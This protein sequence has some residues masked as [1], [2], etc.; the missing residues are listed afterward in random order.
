MNFPCD[1]CKHQNKETC[2]NHKRCKPWKT[3][4]KEEWKEVTTRV[5]E[6]ESENNG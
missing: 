5:K 2:T 3:W 1:K 6:M 4:F